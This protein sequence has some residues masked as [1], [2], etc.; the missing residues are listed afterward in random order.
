M[1][2]NNPL[3]Y[4]PKTDW[5]K[6]YFNQTDTK[7]ELKSSPT[8]YEGS[9]DGYSMIAKNLLQFQAIPQ[10]LIRL[11]PSRLDKGGGIEDI[12]RCNS[13]KYQNCCKMF[14][15]NK[16]ECATKKA[17]EIHNDPRERH[18]KMLRTR[19]K[20]NGASCVKRIQPKSSLSFV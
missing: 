13:A 14:D 9:S 11:D 1:S 5:R 18:S 3:S 15:S 20:C 10:L 8:C 16:L 19:I 7:E 12:L 17:A 2:T 6:C 4:S